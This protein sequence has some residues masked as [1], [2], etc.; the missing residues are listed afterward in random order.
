MWYIHIWIICI[1]LKS[2]RIIYPIKMLIAYIASTIH[3]YSFIKE[4]GMGCIHARTFLSWS[5]IYE[6]KF[7]NGQPRFYELAYLLPHFN[8]L[9]DTYATNVMWILNI[10][11]LMCR[12]PNPGGWKKKKNIASLDSIKEE[13]ILQ[14]YLTA[15]ETTTEGMLHLKLSD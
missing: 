9:I 5:G 12:V 1:L 4:G 3:T 15:F 2:S 8:F 6:R 7:A 14:K 13:N 11:M 10:K